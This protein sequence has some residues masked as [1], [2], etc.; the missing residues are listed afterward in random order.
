MSSGYSPLFSEVVDFTTSVFQPTDDYKPQMHRTNKDTTNDYHEK[1]GFSGANMVFYQNQEYPNP[2]DAIKYEQFGP[3]LSNPVM[4]E[5]LSN[6]FARTF[7]LT[8]DLPLNVSAYP[9]TPEQPYQ[10]QSFHGS[11]L[12]L[13]SDSSIM[14]NNNMAKDTMLCLSM[15]DILPEPRKTSSSSGI[16]YT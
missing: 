9:N 4:K 5:S 15:N 6:E 8:N 14:T 2:F 7:S 11:L 3:M 13:R 1:D 10:Y 12:S 16:F